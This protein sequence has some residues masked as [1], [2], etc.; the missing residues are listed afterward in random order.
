MRKIKR[1]YC[2]SQLLLAN[3]PA[4]VGSN[5]SRLKNEDL[6]QEKKILISLIQV[7]K[8]RRNLK[9]IIISETNTII[10]WQPEV[11]NRAFI[12]SSDINPAFRL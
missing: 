4:I 9:I 2:T 1:N 5:I 11:T 3:F 8:K 6:L 10:E 12:P 7:K